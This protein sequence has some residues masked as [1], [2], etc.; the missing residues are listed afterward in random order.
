ML[1]PIRAARLAACAAVVAVCRLASA[2][3][4][5]PLPAPDVSSLQPPPHTAPAPVPGHGT[6]PAPEGDLPPPSSQPTAQEDAP[7][8]PA[9]METVVRAARPYTAASSRS[10][11]DRDFLLRP[12]PR[13]VDILQVVPGLY[14]NQHAGGGKANQY[15]LRGFDADHG[16]DVALSVDGV[17]VNALS[18]GHGQGYA[19]LNWVIPEVVQ[20]VDVF[21]GTYFP[22]LGDFATAGAVNLATRESA[23][24]SQVTLGAGSFHTYR[25]LGMVSPE[26][27]GWRS[28]LAA[29][30]YGTDGPFDSPE[31]LERYS[32]FGK[33]TRALSP[34]SSLSVAVTS[35]ASGWNA[36]GQLPLREVEA[37]RLSRFGTLDPDEGGNSQRH[38]VYAQYR[39][40]TGGE[41]E[42]QALAYLVSSRLNLYSNF[43]F[44]SR[45]PVNG[46]MIEQT[47]ARTTAGFQGSYR[48]SHALGGVRFDTTLGGQLRT[49][50]VDNGLYDARARERLATNVSAAVREG[51]VGAYVQEDV[52][53]T[54][55]LRA[56]VGLRADAFGFSVEDRLEDLD[57]QGSKSSGVRQ[58]SQLSPKASLVVS[59][60]PQT[61]LYVNFGH[62]FHSND[63]RGVV[64]EPDAVTPLTRAR[65]YE[66]GARTRLFERL[67]LA[68]S[69][70]LLDLDSELVWVG[71]AGSTEA[72]GATR[73]RGLEAEARVQLL[74]WLFAD[75]DLT[76][77]R[78]TYVQNAG[79]ADAV[80]LAPTFLLAGGLSAR[81]PSGVYGR[82]GALHVADRPAT[83]DRFI[84]AEGF[85]RVDATLGYRARRFEVNLGVQNLLD[86]QW[87]EAQFANVS[88]LPAETGPQACPA[89]TRAAGEA[90]AFEG[91][92]DLHFTPGAPLN[93][94]LSVSFFF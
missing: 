66:V 30:V 55:W 63:A 83:E 10:V 20:R 81:H 77:S 49:D 74:S 44:F 6:A 78:A 16:T 14:A 5:E 3:S 8:E 40:F 32:L 9:R 75:A 94:Q 65:G 42:V 41:G 12:R 71:D 54:P 57:T 91:C 92:E 37:G 15:F 89:G 39:A 17:P 84:Q 2:Q 24:Q 90:G 68:A 23:E 87:R 25:V 26:L 7:A 61:D 38:S 27:E 72:R 18:H 80:A 93:G 13:P 35:Y 60:L 4:L 28:L 79:N 85:T 22:Q 64:R 50:T 62:G 45:D 70:F 48:F 29:Q 47:D 34:R 53:L 31:Q 76:L 33:L 11:R 56:L 1:R 58:A 67:D 69:V 21:K 52:T 43:T 59:P 46:D 88:R 36:S 86:T 51:S 19:D 73:R 82:L